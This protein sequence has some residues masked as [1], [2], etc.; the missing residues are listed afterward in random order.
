LG[1]CLQLAAQL[2]AQV[3]GLPRLPHDG[4]MDR[5]A[6]GALGYVPSRPVRLFR[7]REVYRFSGFLHQAVAPSILRYEG[8]IGEAD[9]PIHHYGFLRSDRSKSTFYQALAR[10]QVAAEPQN[11][12]AWIELGVVLFPDD[13]DS[14][15]R[16]FRR[17][18]SLGLL[19]TAGFYTGWTLIEKRRPAAGI[20]FLHQAIRG[21]PRD[22]L[23]D[24]D[25][26]DAW[27]LLGHAYEMLADARKAERAYRRAIA[28][29]PDS[30]AAL[31]NLAGL[32]VERGAVPQAERL[33]Q[34]LLVRYRGLAMP[35]A[36]L[37]KL[38]LRRGD[39]EGARQAFGTAL[40]ID[41][42]CLPAR[43]NL[44]LACDH[45][46]LR[47]KLGQAHASARKRMNTHA[48]RRLGSSAKLPSRSSGSAQRRL[49][50][51]G[52]GTVVSLIIH[53][54]DGAGRVLINA[55]NALRGRPQLVLCGDAGSY[56]GQDF[57]AEVAAA[58]VETLTVDSLGALRRT[59][60]HVRP[61]CV[62]HHWWDTSLF[63]GP[64]RTGNERW[65][66]IGHAALP[67]PVGYDAYVVLS[68]YHSRLQAHLPPDRIH[69]IANGVDLRRF[70]LRP[71]RPDTPVTIAMISRLEPGKFP[72]R[73]LA[74]LPPLRELGARLVIAGTGPRRYE[75]EP[76]LE[77]EGMSTAIRF[78][79]P[80]SSDRIPEFLGR[81]DIGLHLTE[82]HQEVC[83]LG[84]LEMLAAGLPV[85]AE[86]NGCLPEVITSGENGVLAEGEREIADRLRCLVLLPAL[87]RRIGA[88]ARRTAREY[89]SARFRSSLAH[90]IGRSTEACA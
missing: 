87:R 61:E 12:R 4:A 5:L 84:I 63:S 72:R 40:D 74:Y 6:R 9:V 90:V 3:G 51:L 50:S 81:A 77:Q 17:A 22:E 82:T 62:I 44:A 66:A 11:P 80:I 54:H 39:L 55:V 23:V 88:A 52:P 89:A 85:V 7:R 36:T 35:W 58:G 19:S 2:G 47:G 69:R 20:P 37:G 43:A 57:R 42:R 1:S 18:R 64:A 14:A 71:E 34:R 29:R 73:L 86:P 45:A 28:A 8:R 13:L 70:R 26:S 59:L 10:R 16:A 31:N 27:E 83:P 46:G 76:E 30:P 56:T 79:G 75:I 68:E 32:L 65:I 60:D 78:T 33:L 25:R 53:L 38:R 48:A 41:P 15:R 21:N 67:M 24:Y 49:R